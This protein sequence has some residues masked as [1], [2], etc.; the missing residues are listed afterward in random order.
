LA[1]LG[2]KMKHCIKTI[3][4][5]IMLSIFAWGLS[6]HAPALAADNSEKPKYNVADEIY[7]QRK[8]RAQRIELVENVKIWVFT[9]EFNKFQR[10]EFLKAVA[11]NNARSQKYMHSTSTYISG[12]KLGPCIGACIAAN[13]PCAIPAYICT[14]E[15]GMNINAKNPSSTASGKYQFLDTTWNGYGGY[16]H[17]SDAPESVQDQKAQE[18]WNNGAGAGNWACC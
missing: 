15:S 14:R 12:H 13:M 1:N 3:T 17:A 11:E 8:V 2:E 7:I 4:S 10:N 18:V 6:F 9:V 5:I 16:T